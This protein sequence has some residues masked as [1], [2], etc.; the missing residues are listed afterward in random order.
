MATYVK[1]SKT[2]GRN[3]HDHHDNRDHNQDKKPDS[4]NPA[5]ENHDFVNEYRIKE[6]AERK[7]PFG[8]DLDSVR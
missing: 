8:V 1:R 4:G 5:Q 6:L 2:K 3:R 7:G